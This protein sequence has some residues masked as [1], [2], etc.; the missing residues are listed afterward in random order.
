MISIDHCCKIYSLY[1]FMSQL[2]NFKEEKKG[3]GSEADWESNINQNGCI[4]KFEDTFIGN[5]GI[6]GGEWR[7]AI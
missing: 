1:R 5:I 3:C 6:I 2:T 4:G 7:K